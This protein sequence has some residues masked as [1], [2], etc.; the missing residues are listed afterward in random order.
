LKGIFN[1]F[2]VIWNNIIILFPSIPTQKKTQNI[3]WDSKVPSCTSC[4]GAYSSLFCKPICMFYVATSSFASFVMH[5]ITWS[6]S[7]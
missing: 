4:N 1:F 7:I 3:L 6:S 2:M 5:S